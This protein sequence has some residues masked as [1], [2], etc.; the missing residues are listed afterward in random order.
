MKVQDIATAKEKLA[1]REGPKKAS[2]NESRNTHIT[3]LMQC[4]VN[5]VW[6]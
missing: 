4:N 5:H 3:A 2:D 6:K 1:D